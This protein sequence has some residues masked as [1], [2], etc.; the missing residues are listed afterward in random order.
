MAKIRVWIVCA[1]VAAAAV[2]LGAD[3]TLLVKPVLIRDNHLVVSYELADAYNAAVKDA[4]TSGL[5]TTFTYDLQ[6]RTK[7]PAWIDRV[8]ATVNVTVSDQYDNLTRR[9]HL[10]RMVDG[11]IDGDTSTEDDAVVKAWL[12]TGTRVPLCETSHVDSTRDYYVRVTAQTRP[13]TGF[14]GLPRTVSGQ[15]K[16]T[17][18]P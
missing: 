9:H 13:G 14:L 11:R 1:L 18:I 4:I 2:A 10:T 7:V 5:R 8:I 17:F 6:L 15:V 16:F 3:E 12:T